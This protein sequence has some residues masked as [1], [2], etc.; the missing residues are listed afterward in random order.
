MTAA[1]QILSIWVPRHRNNVNGKRVC[2]KAFKTGKRRRQGE[3]Q[4]VYGMI[5]ISRVNL[6]N[7]PD[8]PTCGLA[9]IA[10]GKQLIWFCVSRI[11]NN[12]GQQIGETSD[13]VSPFEVFLQHYFCKMNHL[14][15]MDAGYICKLFPQSFLPTFSPEENV[16]QSASEWIV[17][18]SVQDFCSH[19]ATGPRKNP[20]AILHTKYQV[21]QSSLS[22]SAGVPRIRIYLRCLCL[23]YTST[24]DAHF[25]EV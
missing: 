15:L 22:S 17:F 18:L 24:H 7:S 4:T 14:I 9:L 6:L 20:V 12:N 2:A 21:Y 10:T 5:Y 19:N 3:Y 25:Q 16:T 11:G 8:R 23:Q 1:R 13:E